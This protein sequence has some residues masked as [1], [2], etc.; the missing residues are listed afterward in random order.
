MVDFEFDWEFYVWYYPDLQEAD[1][2]TE[3]KAIVH[4]ERY[5]KVENRVGKFKE[6]YYDE[7]YPELGLN[8]YYAARD[9]YMTSGRDDG[10]IFEYRINPISITD[11]S[12]GGVLTATT[13]DSSQNT[14]T[15][16]VNADIKSDAAIDATKIY[17]GGVSN[18]K[19][20]YLGDVNSALV[21]IN[22]TQTLTNKTINGSFIGNVVGDVTGDITGD[23]TGNLSGK[24]IADTMIANA[25][26]VTGDYT[27]LI[28]DYILTVNNTTFCTITLPDPT[29][30]IGQIIYVVDSNGNAATHNIRVESA[31]GATIVGNSH[32]L[33][34]SNY[35]TI[36]FF[37]DGSQ[38]VVI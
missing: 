8:N 33:L 37:S 1:I 16:I 30:N 11:V 2:D 6:A 13:I 34:T 10:K 14:I 27:V 36:T 7:N 23:I 17:D 25:T 3:A 18:V 35:E 24:I 9:H 20:R 4:W 12:T 21:G 15:N 29:T 22:D 19:F 28:T 32:F 5:G 26:E 38:Y 31:G